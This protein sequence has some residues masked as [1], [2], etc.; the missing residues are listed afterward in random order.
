MRSD[1]YQ[2][3]IGASPVSAGLIEMVVLQPTSFC[4]ID[5]SYCYLPNRN[6][7]RRMSGEVLG[8]LL[9]RLL[10]SGRLGSSLTMLWHAGEPLTLPVSY[11]DKAISMVMARLPSSV[12]VTHN[13][14]TNGMLINEEWCDFF[15]RPDVRVGVS[16]DGPRNLHDLHRTTRRGERTFDQTIA[17]LRMLRTCGVELRVISVLTRQAL[18]FPDELFD[19]YVAEGVSHVAFNIDEIDGINPKS[20][21]EDPRCEPLFTQF[22]A[23]FIQRCSHN[24]A[25]K[26]VRELDH[27]FSAIV[28]PRHR[29]VQNKPFAIVSVAA[30][31]DFTTYSPELLGMNSWPVGRLRPR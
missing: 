27:V 17:G 13:F 3:S 24:S 25:I 9:E 2:S 23:R 28:N 7:K 16:I 4:N 18:F 29:D 19:F 14:Q 11:Y 6:A 20:S 8:A 5:C 15:R 10:A 1:P 26:S 31:G 12:A 22:F 21:L 30:D